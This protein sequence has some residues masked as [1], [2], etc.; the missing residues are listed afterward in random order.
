[1]LIKLNCSEGRYA[2]TCKHTELSRCSD[3][4][5]QSRGF[6]YGVFS[7]VLRFAINEFICRIVPDMMTIFSKNV[8]RD[9]SV[10]RVLPR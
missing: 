8:L 1:M 3:E 7:K 9:F 2:V 5:P 6:A 10:F 4:K